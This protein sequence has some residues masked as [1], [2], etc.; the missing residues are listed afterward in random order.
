VALSYRMARDLQRDLSTTCPDGVT[1]TTLWD[2]GWTWCESARLAQAIEH[3]DAVRSHL[4]SM[5][6]LERAA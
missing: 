4:Y 5:R 2:D 6:L 3:R 1:I